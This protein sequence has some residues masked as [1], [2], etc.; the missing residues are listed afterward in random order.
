MVEK[1]NRPK[2]FL[3]V[4]YYYKGNYKVAIVNGD[5]AIELGFRAHP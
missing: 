3:S 1:K 5:R 4:D 2:P